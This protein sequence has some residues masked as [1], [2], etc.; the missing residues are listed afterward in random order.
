MPARRHVGGD[1]DI[2]RAVAE[3]AE[4]LFTLGLRDV[5]VQHLGGIAAGGEPRC[6]FVGPDLGAGEDDAVEF[7]LD[8][9]DPGQGVELVGFAHLE[10]DLLGEVG[11]ELLVLDA[12]DLRVAHVGFREPDDA[13]GHRRR[14]E[15]HA[16]LLAGVA[17][18]LLDV[19]HEAH[20]EHFVGFVQYEVTDV[21]EF[22]RAAADVVQHAARRADDDIDAFGEPAQLFAHRGA[23]VDGS[24]REPFSRL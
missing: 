2:D 20:V 1:E 16:P 15:Q 5:A 19:L 14:E 6:G 10:V 23:A 24:D 7:G 18:D 12:H 9:D 4:Y 13:F 21:F 8:V 11:R 3:L 22:Q 17:H